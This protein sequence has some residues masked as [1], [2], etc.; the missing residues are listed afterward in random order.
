MAFEFLT[1]HS[2]L[3]QFNSNTY[4]LTNCNNDTKKKKEKTKR[5]KRR[6]QHK[7]LL[8]LFLCFFNKNRKKAFSP[9]LALSTAKRERGK[10]EKYNTNELKEEEKTKLLPDVWVYTAFV[11]SQ[12]LFQT[13]NS[14]GVKAVETKG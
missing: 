7:T 5:K 12:I 6:W 11:Q 1:V 4:R 14:F 2:L 13:E 10:T 8:F 3:T 9:I